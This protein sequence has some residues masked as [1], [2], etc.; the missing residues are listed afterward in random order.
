MLTLAGGGGCSGEVVKPSANDEQRIKE[1]LDLKVQHG[2][3]FAAANGAR[4]PRRDEHGIDGEYDAF[5]PDAEDEE[6]FLLEKARNRAD[7]FEGKPVR[8]VQGYN[9]DRTTWTRSDLGCWTF[10]TTRKG[11]PRWRYVKARTS[12]DNDSGEV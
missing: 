12:I 1:F 11:G 2:E 5:G 6:V 9:D 4:R 7:R 3:V 8:A 10:R